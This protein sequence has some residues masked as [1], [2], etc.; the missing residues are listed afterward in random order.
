M[1]RGKDETSDIDRCYL[2]SVRL[3]ELLEFWVSL[4]VSNF[5]RMIWKY[6][7]QG[8]WWR[9]Q[10]ETFSALLALC[11]GEFSDEFPL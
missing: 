5:A 8:T 10:M 3:A 11:K 9:H 4:H 2:L 1:L 6:N 7:E